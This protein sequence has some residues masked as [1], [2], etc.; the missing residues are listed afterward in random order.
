MTIML[1]SAALFAATGVSAQTWREKDVDYYP[2]HELQVH[3]GTP[4]ILE[5]TT[6]LARPMITGQGQGESRNHIFSGAAGVGYSFYLHPTVS[7]GLDFGTSYAAADIVLTSDGHPQIPAGSVL[8]RSAVTTWTGQLSGHWTYFQAGALD[9]SCGL[10]VGLAYLDESVSQV[11]D[12]PG[13]QDLVS[14]P[15]DRAKLAYH[16]TAL[17][18]RYGEV[19][20]IYGELGF[21]YRGLLNVGLS[22]KL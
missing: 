6:K 16:F 15:K 20:G 10:Y 11:F 4:T 21:G 18:V 14:F 2:Q 9:I 5:L 19:F 7:I 12:A 22:V 13:I 3:Y 1:V 17:K 8:Y